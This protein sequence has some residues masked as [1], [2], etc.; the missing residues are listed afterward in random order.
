MNEPPEITAER[1]V[2]EVVTQILAGR[3]VAPEAM[4]RFLWP[5]YE[6]DAH[7]P[8]LLTDM[9]PAVARI[10][11]AA[12]RGERVAVYGDYDIDGITASAVML[13]A[14][15]ALGVRAES[16][17]PD[18]F[19]EGYGI[20]QG[21]LEALAARGVTLV[22]S[23]D[24]GITSAHE[25]VWAQEHGLDLIITDHHAVPP[26]IPEA[27]A[28]I[29][30]KRPGDQYPFKELAG[31]GVAF[32]VVRAMQAR[33]GCPAVG[34]EKWLLDLVA[35]G[36][37]CDVVPLVGENRMLVTYGLKVLRQ[38]R[39]PGITQLAMVA[40][41]VPAELDT[42]ALGFRLGPRM[43][44]AGR[45]EHA[46][47]SLELVRTKD[48]HRAGELAV[49]LD[50]RN[51][52]RRATQDLITTA[53]VA[54]AG[55]Y[56]DDPVLVLAGAD[57]S[58]G[59]VG[60]VASKL[61]EKFGKPVLVGQILGDDTKGSA[62]SVGAF[63]M[64]EALRANA[65][66]LSKY[67]G[68]FFAAGFTLPT[69]RLDELRAGL[70]EYFVS[71]GACAYEVPIA[72]AEV[73]FGDLGGIDWDLLATFDLLQPYGRENPAPLIKITNVP[74]ER[75]ARIGSAGQ[76]LRLVICDQR[77]RR[78]SAVGFGLSER[79]STLRDGQQL[80]L[81]GR[82]NKNEFQGKRSLQLIL[83]RIEYE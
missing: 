56:V 41:T 5:D 31:V 15:E 52:E 36:T 19:E 75:V 51:R 28:V 80:T 11:L 81:V 9:E 55:V 45:L 30:P 69:E 64:V 44:A 2:P 12:E 78:L 17:I 61:V 37:V 58:H 4:E 27:V 22:V 74:C 20:N 83:E 25:A 50:Q 65:T 72:A 23:V 14:L 8:W 34:Q 26:I 42:E 10:R 73:S 43:N 1:L 48:V 57:W 40:G 70:N 62:R 46:A 21:A 71:S 60:V 67:G 68:H 47:G 82:L 77:G 6:R 7:D 3:G 38:T 24:C 66:L 79:Y 32:Q 35:L 53:A 63:N 29:N 33:L 59:V 18:R 54:A 39:R 49:R 76:H 13:E 16:Y